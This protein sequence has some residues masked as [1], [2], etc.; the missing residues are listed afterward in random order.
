MLYYRPFIL[1]FLRKLVYYLLAIGTIVA[2]ITKHVRS[3]GSVFC[4]SYSLFSYPK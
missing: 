3:R 4:I 1:F 2:K